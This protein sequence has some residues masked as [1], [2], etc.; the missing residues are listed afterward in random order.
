MPRARVARTALWPAERL[1]GG[2]HDRRRRQPPTGQRQLMLEATAASFEDALGTHLAACDRTLRRVRRER[3]V[4]GSPARRDSA[5]GRRR[6]DDPRSPVQFSSEV[7]PHLS[8]LAGELEDDG[9]AMRGHVRDDT[10]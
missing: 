10:W 7:V 6:V 1:C 8:V 5:H 9:N 3:V 4:G 2:N